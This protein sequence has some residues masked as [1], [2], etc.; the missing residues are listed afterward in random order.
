MSYTKVT[1]DSYI[2]G[3]QWHQTRTVGSGSAVP[4]DSISDW[5]T[6]L[7]ATTKSGA[8]NPLWRSQVGAGSSAGTA[9][10][11]SGY[12]VDTYRQGNVS[13]SYSAGT[14]GSKVTMTDAFQGFNFPLT[15]PPSYIGSFSS[16]DAT[17]LA[18]VYR[19]IDQQATQ[20]QGLNFFAEFSDVVRQFGH[21]FKSILALTHRHLNRLESSKRGLSGS[22]ST[23]REKMSKI[24][25]DTYLEYAFGLAPLISD[26]K[27]AAEALARYEVEGNPDLNPVLRARVVGRGSST[28]TASPSFSKVLAYNSKIYGN[29]LIEQS[30]EA[31]VQYIVGLRTAPVADYGSNK[32]L[33]GLLGFQPEKFVPALWEAVPW[34]WLIDYFGNVSDVLF[35]VGVDTSSVNWINKTTVMID[36]LQ[37]V[38]TFSAIDSQNLA[39]AYGY[40]SFQYAGTEMGSWK[41]RRTTL[42]RTVPSALGWPSIVW[43]LPIGDEHLDKK[44]AALAAVLVQRRGSLASF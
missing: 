5:S 15:N 39:R 23:R 31:R 37:K 14:G 34:S 26:A 17:A 30:S 18:Q 22:V 25:A 36:L 42:T 21:P 43:S 28:I 7:L 16:P 38:C 32:R 33:I 8:A 9:Y 3:G 19:K 1:K 2:A 10:S 40:T 11:L 20:W 13:F 27:K 12:R 41:I 35:S 4:W 44:L 24:V 29:V 6:L